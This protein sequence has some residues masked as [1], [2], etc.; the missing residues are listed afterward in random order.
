M[1]V[2]HIIGDGE[3]CPRIPNDGRN[4]FF[5]ISALNLE[6]TMREAL[7]GEG[8]GGMEMLLLPCVEPFEANMWLG[9]R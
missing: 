4:G 6:G 9:T 1:E 2:S 3:A 8:M 5:G 7:R